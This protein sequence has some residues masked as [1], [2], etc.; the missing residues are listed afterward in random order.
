MLLPDVSQDVQHQSSWRACANGSTGLLYAVL[1]YEGLAE[2]S[3]IDAKSGKDGFNDA[4][5][6]MFYDG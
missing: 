2:P 3:S 6:G 4:H 1:A 5:G